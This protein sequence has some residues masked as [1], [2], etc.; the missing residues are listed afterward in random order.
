[1][2]ENQ[3]GGGG[4]YKEAKNYLFTLDLKFKEDYEGKRISLDLGDIF[5]EKAINCLIFPELK[6]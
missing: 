4:G 5:A 2:N 6:Y 3:K 1:M